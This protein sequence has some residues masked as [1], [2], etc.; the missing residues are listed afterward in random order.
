MDLSLSRRHF[1]LQG[2]SGLSAIWISTHWS[3][4]LAASDHAHKAA[5]SAT[6]PKLQFLTTEE[7][8]EIDAIAARIIPSDDTPGA[9][10]AGIVYFVDRALVTFGADDQKTY[11]EGLPEMQARV[12]EMFPS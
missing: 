5:R 4:L 8:K 6:P 1:L 12:A 7:A 11:R 10:E 9:R 3:A 2:A